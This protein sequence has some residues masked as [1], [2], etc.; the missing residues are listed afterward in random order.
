MPYNG[1]SPAQINLAAMFGGAAKGNLSQDQVSRLETMASR[2]S[3]GSSIAKG[4]LKKYQASQASTTAAAGAAAQAPSVV[5]TAGATNMGQRINTIESRLQAL[6]GSGVSTGAAQPVAGAAQPAAEVA[7]QETQAQAAASQMT[8]TNQAVNATSLIGGFA[9]P[10][11]PV[12]DQAAAASEELGSLMASPFTMRQRKNMGP[13][14]FKD[15]TGDGKIT[16]ADVIKA[17]VEGYK[18]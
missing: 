10:I 5:Q 17:R 9:K 1:K 4:L 13:L 6:E 2:N 16:R 15:Q 8:D 12:A 7:P 14:M 18:K 3:F 11:P